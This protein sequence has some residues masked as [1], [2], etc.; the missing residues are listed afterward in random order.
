MGSF[1]SGY[2]RL[3]EVQFG[4]TWVYGKIPN[5]TAVLDQPA[6]LVVVTREGA[7]SNAAD[8]QF[9]ATR[10]V[11][12][13][14]GRDVKVTR[15]GFDSNED[16]CN[17]VM[18]PSDA[19]DLMP[20]TLDAALSAAHEN[21]WGCVGDDLDIDSYEI[22]LKNQWILQNAEVW[23]SDSVRR[24]EAE[25]ISGIW[26]FPPGGIYW[27]AAMQWRVTPNDLLLYSV[28]VD[29]VGPKDVPYK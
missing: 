24:G 28:F 18:D 13:L 7:G 9:R 8:V 17:G 1:Q 6:K 20:Y 3:E 19:Q 25:I 2:L 29:I 26:D 15:C 14:S 16:I 10:E 23:T 12:A 11:L 21:C 22:R 5:V 27:P 4:G